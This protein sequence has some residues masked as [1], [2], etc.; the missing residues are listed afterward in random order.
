VSG[1][2]WEENDSEI[3]ISFQ[4]PKGTKPTEVTM[5]KYLYI[6]IYIHIYIEGSHVSGYTWEE[7][8]SEIEISF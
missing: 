7:N 2:T 5:I 4:L 6:E 3:E 1:Y 8:D